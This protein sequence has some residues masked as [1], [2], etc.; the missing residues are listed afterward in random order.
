MK[1]NWKTGKD[2]WLI[3]LAAGL[4]LLI[5]TFPAGS[6]TP[7]EPQPEA[8]AGQNTGEGESSKLENQ[9]YESQLEER[10][11]GILEHVEGV[12]EVDVMV[13]LKSSEE[14]IFRVDTNLSGSSTEEKDSQGGTRTVT[15]NQQQET[16]ILTGSGDNGVPIVEKELRPEIEGIII[17]AQG[18]ADLTV[19]AEISQAMEALFG[20]P[21]HK[22]K[23]LKRVD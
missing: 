2:K 8:L 9:S 15:E 13:V 4:I 17:S 18:G 1:F 21:Q 16:T 3:L 19:Q 12:G 10:I 14:K 5:L 7:S 6:K 22:I 20:L 11:A 23:V